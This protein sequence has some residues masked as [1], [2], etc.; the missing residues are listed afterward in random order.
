MK[1]SYGWAMLA[2]LVFA[3]PAIADQK[4]EDELPGVIGVESICDTVA[5]KLDGTLNYS[6]ALA[7]PDNVDA[8]VLLGPLAVANDGT[9][10]L[11]VV[12]SINMAHTWIGDIVAR[13]D[14]YE[15]CESPNP[16]ASANVICRPGSN[17]CG[18][19]GTTV[20]CS[21]NFVAA[22][23]IRINDLAINSLPSAA[24]VSATNVPA[25]CYRPTG[26]G[27]G[28]M[29]VFTGLR[30][31]GCFKLFLQDNEGLDVGT[32]TSW[33]VYSINQNPTPSLAESWGGVKSIYR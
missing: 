16:S 22:N 30:K 3:A 32:V 28:S 21:S 25:G 31:G 20:G 9:T 8:G 11:N 5:L 2:M 18:P 26:V 7:I 33:S 12:F 19:A 6:P 23:Q 4:F 10:F 29:A 13:L 24:C 15:D 1:R 27:A 14:Y 17:A